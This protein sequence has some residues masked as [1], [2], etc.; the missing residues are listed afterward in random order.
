MMMPIDFDAQIRLADL[1][2]R[3]T[4][5]EPI[6][7]QEMRELLLDLRRGREASATRA[8]AEKRTVAKASAPKINLRDLFAA[9]AEPDAP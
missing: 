5:G 6:T 1:R 3:A 8:A 7:A 2:T 4:A 9:S